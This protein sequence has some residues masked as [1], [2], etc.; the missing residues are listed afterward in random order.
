MTSDKALTAFFFYYSTNRQLLKKEVSS[1]KTMISANDGSSKE[2]RL[3]IQQSMWSLK[4]YGENG[5]EWSLEKKFEQMAKAGFEGIFSGLPMKE[6]EA[7]WRRLMTEYKFH[8]GLEAF[9]E[10]AEDLRELLL[11]AADYDVLYVNAQVPDAF[12]IG[13]EAV[14]RLQE[15]MEEADSFGIPLFIETHRGRLTQ[16][17]LRTADYVKTLPE[18]RLTIDF[19]HYVLAGEMAEFELAEPYFDQLLKRTS[20]IH[21]R[22]TNAQQIQ[23]DVGEGTHPMVEP[24]LNWWQKGMHYWRDEAKAGDVLPYVCEIGHHYS[25]TKNFQPGYSWDEYS[26]RWQQSLV[27]KKLAEKAWRNS[28][29]DN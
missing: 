24:F 18:L 28:E 22:I 4:H 10:K 23:I 7:L 26:D 14:S 29:H 8:F 11:K 21:G 1:L 5:K 17:L 2:P 27:F 16:D 3:L 6:E 19:S 15:L 13:Q 25:V 9:P 12:T 20:C